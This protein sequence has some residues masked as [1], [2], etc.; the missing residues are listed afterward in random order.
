MQCFAL[1][2]RRARSLSLSLVSTNIIR[3]N[4]TSSA[5]CLTAASYAHSVCAARA[6]RTLLTLI[7]REIVKCASDCVRLDLCLIEEFSKDS[8]KDTHIS[9][10]LYFIFKVCMISFYYNYCKLFMYSFS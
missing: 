2:L 10:G 9:A 1:S 4:R 8:F 3:K 7:Y 6:V 5:S